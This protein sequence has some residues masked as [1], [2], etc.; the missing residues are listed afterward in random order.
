MGSQGT[1]TVTLTAVVCSDFSVYEQEVEVFAVGMEDTPAAFSVQ[2]LCSQPC[3]AQSA[4]MDYDVGGEKAILEVFD[5]SGRLMASAILAGKGS[6]PLDLAKWASGVYVYRVEVEGQAVLRE[7][8]VVRCR[9]IVKLLYC[10]IAFFG[11][12]V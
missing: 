3:Y 10:C 4:I 2:S 5:V 1:Y 11:G 12:M 6:Y 8:L 7:K 9:K